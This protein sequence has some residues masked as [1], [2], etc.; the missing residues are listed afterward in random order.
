MRN[1]LWFFLALSLS[2]LSAGCSRHKEEEVVVKIDPLTEA[3]SIVKRYA[4]G[5]PLTSEVASFPKLVA[6]VR[7]VD[8]ARGDILEKGL[9]E[10]QKAS[11][12][13][14]PA[15]ARTLESKLTK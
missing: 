10:I 15:L 2:G 6:D 4:E 5:A 9:A 12:S 14:R 13:A 3:R 1:F 8:P 11:A 7:A